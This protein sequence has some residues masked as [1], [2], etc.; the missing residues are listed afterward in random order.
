MASDSDN[1]GLDDQEIDREYFMIR[2]ERN[3]SFEAEDDVEDQEQTG[4]DLF[5]G[6]APKQQRNTQTDK[7][8]KTDEK[9][10]ALISKQPSTST[11]RQKDQQAP[12][13]TFVDLS[14]LKY[15]SHSVS[16]SSKLSRKKAAV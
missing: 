13:L 9:G 15:L 1:S 14:K 5:G 12:V 10:F 6:Q 7:E 4:D 11:K 16:A 8:I 3:D 2:R